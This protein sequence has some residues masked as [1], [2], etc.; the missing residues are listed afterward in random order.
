MA[1][2]IRYSLP[3]AHLWWDALAMQHLIPLLKRPHSWDLLI[4]HWLGVDH[5][6]HTYGV[7]SRQMEDKLAQMDD[8]VSK[9]IGERFKTCGSVLGCQAVLLPSWLSYGAYLCHVHACL[10]CTGETSLVGQPC[11]VAA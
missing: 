2:L 5:A 8:Q 9:V 7:N 6:G 11:H 3:L 1:V 4:A 10:P